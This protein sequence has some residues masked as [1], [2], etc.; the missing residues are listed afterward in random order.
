MDLPSRL[1]PQ[2]EIERRFCPS[3][4]RIRRGQTRL[5][6]LAP[7]SCSSFPHR[8]TSA[9]PIRDIFCWPERL[10][11]FA[12]LHHAER[13]LRNSQSSAQLKRC[14][15]IHCSESPICSLSSSVAHPRLSPA[16]CATIDNAIIGLDPAPAPYGRFPIMSIVELSR[17]AS[18]SH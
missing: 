7:K 18:S 13:G 14:I 17:F 16:Q 2:G 1:L 8:N 9:S 6:L 11:G 15:P 5:T 4:T 3:W 12:E 10:M